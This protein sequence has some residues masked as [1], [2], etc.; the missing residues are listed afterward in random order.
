MTDSFTAP[1]Y[2]DAVLRSECENCR[3]L[4]ANVLDLSQENERLIRDRELQTEVIDLALGALH[5]SRRNAQLLIPGIAISFAVG[6]FA[7]LLTFVFTAK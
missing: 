4:R 3:S 1:R 6:W 5:E 7:S 2:K